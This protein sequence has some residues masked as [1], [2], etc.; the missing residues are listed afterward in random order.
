M[1]IPSSR[2]KNLIT[3][4]VLHDCGGVGFKG[5]SEAEFD[6]DLKKK[7]RNTTMEI[8]DKRKSID[9]DVIRHIRN[10]QQMY[11]AEGDEEVVGKF[12]MTAA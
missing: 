6:A 10:M 7:I 4:A 5:F 9:G 12:E 8:L 3:A 11:I 2:L 1:S